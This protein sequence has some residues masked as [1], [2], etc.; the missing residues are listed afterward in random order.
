MT[1]L[2]G[3]ALRINTEM[4]RGGRLETLLEEVL[5]QVSVSGSACTEFT[6]NVYAPPPP[7]GL[8]P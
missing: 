7:P 1:R 5:A 4:V 6:C 8:A 2:N 3:A